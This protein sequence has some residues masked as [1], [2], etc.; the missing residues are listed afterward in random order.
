MNFEIKSTGIT[1]NVTNEI[2]SPQRSNASLAGKAYF[3][4]FGK[5][6]GM[7]FS[8]GAAEP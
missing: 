1:E 2:L 8:P 4:P 7:C 5:H 3:Y 6:S